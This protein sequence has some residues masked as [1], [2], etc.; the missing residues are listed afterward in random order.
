M[1][2]ILWVC[3]V[4]LLVFFLYFS[5]TDISFPLPVSALVY[6]LCH[7]C[8]S[9]VYS[10]KTPIWEEQ[11]EIHYNSAWPL[12]EHCNAVVICHLDTS[13]P[14]PEK[15]KGLA[16]KQGT[17]SLFFYR[18]LVFPFSFLFLPHHPTLYC[19]FFV[20]LNY[21]SDRSEVIRLPSWLDM[22]SMVCFDL[23]F[24][25]QAPHTDTVTHT[26]THKCQ[27]QK[28]VHFKLFWG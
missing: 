1:D 26:H 25:L 23:D 4:G 15:N 11:K 14:W 19:F 13:P 20:I 5:F 18:P 8:Y 27:E 12:I 7:T 22:D 2:C 16:F 6:F 21:S 24:L 17:I 3:I 9:F 28:L 10:T